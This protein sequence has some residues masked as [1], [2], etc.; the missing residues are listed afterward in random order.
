MTTG[1]PY[2]RFLFL[3][4]VLLCF[5]SSIALSQNK[6]PN[7]GDMTI[8]AWN[9]IPDNQLTTS[10]F[11]ELKDAG[12]NVNFSFLDKSEDVL[13]ALN[14][15]QKTGIKIIAMTHDIINNPEKQITE[16]KKH[17]ALLGYYIEDEPMSSKFSNI[18]RKVKRFK[19]IDSGHIRYINLLPDHNQETRG[20]AYYKYIKNAIEKMQLQ[21][22]SFDFYPITTKGIN[23]NWYYN[24]ETNYRLAQKNDIDLWAFVLS[25]PHAD[26][27]TPTKASI[28]LQAFSDLAYGVQ[29]IQYFTYWLPTSTDYDYHLAPITDGKRTA[30]YYLV[31]E[32]NQEIHNLAG[33]FKGAKVISVNHI[34][35]IPIGTIRLSK[36]PDGFIN[37]NYKGSHALVSQLINDKKKYVIIQ[38]CQLNKVDSVSIDVFDGMKRVL[39]DGSLINIRNKFKTKIQPGD[40]LIFDNTDVNKTIIKSCDKKTDTLIPNIFA[41]FFCFMI[42]NIFLDTIVLSIMSKSNKSKQSAL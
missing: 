24:L 27:P 19:A 8:V 11:D 18:G 31:K 26:Y 35:K 17:P 30:S 3:I 25:T 6:I 16:I 9:G 5:C 2:K 33:V 23:K 32:M 28:R 21:M 1:N 41:I 15:A 20:D 13:K 37:I 36:M 40:I 12:F 10:R 39:K 38:N 4:T 14:L 34:G 22:L 29:T 7:K 42:L